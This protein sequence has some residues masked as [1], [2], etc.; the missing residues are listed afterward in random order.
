[1][2]HLHYP[3]L[4]ETLVDGCPECEHKGK[5]LMLDIGDAIGALENAINDIERQTKN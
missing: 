2:C 3:E 5:C 4:A 1:M